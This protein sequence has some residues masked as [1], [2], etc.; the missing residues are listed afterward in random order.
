MC[1]KTFYGHLRAV[2]SV[3]VCGQD[4]FISGDFDGQVCIWLA[5]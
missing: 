2:Q 4:R 1:H 5:N 3:S